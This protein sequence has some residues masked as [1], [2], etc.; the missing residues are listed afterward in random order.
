MDYNISILIN[1]QIVR[2]FGREV[3]HSVLSSTQIPELFPKDSGDTY[4]YLFPRETGRPASFRI[5]SPAI[6]SSPLLFSMA[7]EDSASTT[8]RQRARSF[9]GR[10]NLGIEDATRNLDLR[11]RDTP[12]NFRGGPFDNQSTSDGSNESVRSLAEGPR[13]YHIYFPTKLSSNGPQFSERDIQKLVDARNL[14]AFLEG[15][16]LLRTRAAPT[17]FHVLVAVSSL[18]GEFEFTNVDG[19]TFG[20][21]AS[22]AFGWLSNKERL[23]DVSQSREKTI[24]GII[25]GERMRSQELYNEAFAHAVGKY[26]AVKSVK[27]ELFGQI[28]INTRNRLERAYLDL[29]QRQRAAD[30]RL[31]EFEFPSLFAGI[32]ASTSSEESKFVHF[33]AWKSHFM[34][35][36]KAV[37][38]YYKDLHGQWPPKASSKKN[39]FVEGGLNRLVLKGLYVDLC[40]LYDFLADRESLT[41]R[42]FDASDDR[43]VPTVDPT[44]AALRRLLGEF[45]RSSPPVT[46]PIPFDI[47]LVPTMATLNPSYI[48]MGPKEQNALLTKKLKDHESQLVVAKSHNMYSVHNTPFLEMFKAFEAKESRGKNCSQLA[49]M[50]YGHWI[51]MYATLQSLPM[52]VVDAP[53]LRYT[54][55][56]EYF[57]CMPSMGSLPWMEDVVK[58]EWYGVASSGHAVVLP[59]DLVVH[60]VEGIYRR[61]HCWTVAAQWVNEG[62]AG[63]T[64]TATEIN[65]TAALSP[66]QPPPGFA[67]GELGIRPSSR[68]ESR[69][70]IGSPD[71]L[72]PEHRGRGRQSQRNSIA[73]GLE[74]LPIPEGIATTPALPATASRGNSPA[75]L[76]LYDNG[77]RRV[78]SSG[79]FSAR[80]PTSASESRGSTFDDILGSMNTEQPQAQDPGRGRGLRRFI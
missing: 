70:S 25:I 42:G 77:G 9:D 33:K 28:S 41:T 67:G 16:E 66:L 51:F 18:L 61:S 27:P 20:E 7:N 15:Q 65:R 21:A 55:G 3:S 30:L 76:N 35:L 53:G 1:G 58:R 17:L 54:E 71:S 68:D 36:R 34:S 2:N 64:H 38:S 69:N 37:L 46:P 63:S 12:P 31:T 75:G 50:R 13:E 22:T 47:P 43:D 72:A 45:D 78:S 56:V 40:G 19:S 26:E 29:G 73:L 39:T 8:S 60:G 4:I 5:H 52:L 48:G 14:F 80:T 6:A 62:E 74:K 79:P 23:G 24:E 10:N 44:A 57:L 59:S 32:A 11:G 49:D